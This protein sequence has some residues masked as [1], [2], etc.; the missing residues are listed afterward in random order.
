MVL[1]I[2]N[3]SKIL[4]L[5]ISFF[6]FLSCGEYQNSKN[7]YFDSDLGKDTNNGA[8]NKTP[9]KSLDKLLE[10]DLSP[11][12]SIFLSN[13]SSFV[14]NIKLMNLDNVHITNFNNDKE[15]LPIIDSKGHIAGIYIENSSNISISNISITANGGGIYEEYENLKTRRETDKAFM[16]AGVLVNVS[17]NQIFKNISVKNITVK[18]LFFE[19]DGFVRDPSEV[20]TSMGTQ[21]YGFGI[22]FF[23]SSET[24]SID[25]ISV[26]NCYIENIGHTGIKMTSGRNNNRFNNIQKFLIL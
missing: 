15:S 2:K 14:G 4:Q 24:G 3:M 1:K 21:A 22:R 20:K 7:H 8:S 19:N 13:G 18:D 16:R 12:D 25:G 5:I 9:F 23:N 6:F 11:G 17:K 26:K 10:I